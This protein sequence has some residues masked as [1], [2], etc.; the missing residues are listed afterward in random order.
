MIRAHTTD[1]PL[2]RSTD[3][4]TSREAAIRAAKASRRAVEA[5]ESLMAD[6]AGRTDEELYLE[7]RAGGFIASDGVV[8]HARKALSDCGVLV[9]T[10]VTRS[11]SLGS[12]SRVWRMA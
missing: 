11:T 5:V 1:L 9:D 7:L 12:Q 4:H 8:R 2:F 10:G 6:G 3:P